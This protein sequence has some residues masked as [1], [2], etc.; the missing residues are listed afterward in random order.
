MIIRSHDLLEDRRK[1]QEHINKY[2]MTDENEH[3][4]AKLELIIERHELDMRGKRLEL[5][6]LK[7][8]MRI[9]SVVCLDDSPREFPQK[10]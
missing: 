1:T 5:L 4:L 3:G 6:Y 8:K 7:K 9:N 2:G 10:V